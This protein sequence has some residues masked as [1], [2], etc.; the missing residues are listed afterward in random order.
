MREDL[1]IHEKIEAYLS[2]EMSPT[3]KAQFEDQLAN[4][5]EL[6]KKVNAQKLLIQAIKRKALSNQINA[7]AK[8]GGGFSY[9]GTG[10]VIGIVLIVSAVSIYFYNWTSEVNHTTL[11]QE[12]PISEAAILE[13]INTESVVEEAVDFEVHRVDTLINNSPESPINSIKLTKKDKHIINQN[14]LS[15]RKTKDLGELDFLIEVGDAAKPLL[16]ADKEVDSVKRLQRFLNETIDGS[17]LNEKLLGK[18][19]AEFPGG[20]DSLNLFIAQNFEMPSGHKKK[21]IILIEL[22]ILED[23][24]ISKDMKIVQGLTRKL[25]FKAVELVLKMPKWEP[26]TKNGKPVRSKYILPIEIAKGGNSNESD[27]DVKKLDLGPDL[28]KDKNVFD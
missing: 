22:L 24:R 10:I 3:E 28:L 1:K 2:D 11:Q 6:T 5:S 8:G 23:G 20:I 17:D 7:I 21:G 15:Q 19:D 18:T 25:N 4:S 12:E 27:S 16:V 26:A 14:S 9:L 13:L